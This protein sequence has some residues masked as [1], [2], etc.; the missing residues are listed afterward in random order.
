MSSPPDQDQGSAPPD[1]PPGAG[2]RSSHL[3]YVA[4]EIRNPLS[5]ALWT[6][7]LLARLSPV[8]RGGARGEKL[9]AICLRSVGRVRLLVEDHLLC[10]RLDAGGYPLRVEKVPLQEV[11][12]TMQARWPAG[13]GT[14]TLPPD[15]GLVARADRT[16]LERALDGLLATAAADDAPV[17]L[18]ASASQGRLEIRVQGAPPVPLDDPGRG[19]PSEQRGRSLAVPMARRVALAL[20]GSLAVVEGGY[21]LAIPAA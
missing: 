10:E 16:L 12:A 15:Q 20:G 9:A 4:H 2:D 21:L 1:G 11:L 18:E 7:E 3:S 19:A 13:A 14:L 17:R 8:E 5:T 6:S